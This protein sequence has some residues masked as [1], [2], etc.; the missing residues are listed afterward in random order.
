MLLASRT[1]TW[2]VPANNPVNVFED[3]Q[4]VPSIE[5]SNE[6]E[7]PVA[8][9]TVMEALAFPLHNVTFTEE[10]VAVIIVSCVSV[11]GVEGLQL[12]VASATETVYVPIGKFERTNVRV[13]ESK[14]ETACV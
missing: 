11:T 5:Y 2:Y 1:E 13:G 4:V 3:C 10:T 9:L 14:V 7:P 8:A 6:P 12:L